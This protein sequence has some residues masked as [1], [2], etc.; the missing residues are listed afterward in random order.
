MAIETET[1]PAEPA[2]R[3]LMLLDTREAKLLRDCKGYSDDPSGLP[4]HRLM[5][6]VA[7]LAGMVE[8][9]H[10][11]LDYYGNAQDSLAVITGATVEELTQRVGTGGFS[12]SLFF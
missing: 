1:L 5:M 9:Q 4:A 3:W 2:L 7:K 11:L 12:L 8:R 6:L 10:D